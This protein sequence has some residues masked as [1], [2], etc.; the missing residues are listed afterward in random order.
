MTARKGKIQGW[1]RT[2]TMKKE[3]TDVD[4]DKPEK[5]SNQGVQRL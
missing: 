2:K 3:N 1:R 5:N 4:K